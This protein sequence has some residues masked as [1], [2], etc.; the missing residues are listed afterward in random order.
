MQFYGIDWL[1]TAAGLSGVYLLGNK[2]KLGFI[3]FMVASTSWAIFGLM[4]GSIA[5]TLGSMIF[6]TMH[7]RG[8]LAWRRDERNLAHVSV[9]K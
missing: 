3:L 9:A 8:F 6:F 1:A 5:M 4:T 7:L 2:R